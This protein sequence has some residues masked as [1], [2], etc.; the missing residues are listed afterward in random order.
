MTET[1]VLELITTGTMHIV[2]AGG[3]S[4]DGSLYGFPTLCGLRIMRPQFWTEKD[5]LTANHATCRRCQAI[6][7]KL[8]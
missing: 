5:D 2:V 8:K 1:V 6:C 4:A 7:K 3:G